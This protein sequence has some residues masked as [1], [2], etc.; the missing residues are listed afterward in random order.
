M[1][2]WLAPFQ[3][4]ST[5]LSRTLSDLVKCTRQLI[6]GLVENGRQ[7]EYLLGRWRNRDYMIGRAR[8]KGRQKLRDKNTIRRHIRIDMCAVSGTNKIDTYNAAVLACRLNTRAM[9]ASLL[10]RPGD[11]SRNTS[12]T[13]IPQA[14]NNRF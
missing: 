7:Q 4:S 12:I 11:N 6:T 5:G 13:L 8:T 2:D 3:T 1:Q 10:T 9:S 14:H